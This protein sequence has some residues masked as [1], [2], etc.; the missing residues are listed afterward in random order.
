MAAKGNRVRSTKVEDEP[1]IIESALKAPRE[2]KREKASKDLRPGGRFEKIKAFFGDERLHKFTGLLLLLFSVFMLIAFTS[3][4]FTW[5]QD[6]DKVSGSLL[7]LLMSPEIRVDNWLGKF[8]AVLSHSFI[9]KWFGVSAFVFV[10]LSFLTGFKILFRVEL[11][12]IVKTLKYSFFTFI[13]LA[14]TLGYL[15]NSSSEFLYMSG[16]FGFEINRWLNSIFGSIGTGMILGFTSIV[17]VVMV[18]KVNFVLP[19]FL[20][21]GKKP[22]TEVEEAL[23]IV[24]DPLSGNRIK[25]DVVEITDEEEEIEMELELSPSPTPPDVENSD[26]KSISFDV[27]EQLIPVPIA[28]TELEI[29][30]P[31]MEQEND[32]VGVPLSIE[33]LPSDSD[34]LDPSEVNTEVLGEYDPK[35]DLSSYKFPI[36]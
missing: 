33:S 22:E 36:I 4:F 26:E 17:F 15:F 14:A 18:F 25:N 20:L 2:R 19:S 34:I 13:F 29:E 30:L 11:L 8:G 24:A 23:S 7:D 35:L 16:A 9:A 12:P 21:A 31:A 6:H 10:L 5:K 27:E 1:E 32:Q 28:S 3:F